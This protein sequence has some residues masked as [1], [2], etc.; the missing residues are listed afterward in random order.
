MGA[1]WPYVFLVVHFTSLLLMSKGQTCFFTEIAGQKGSEML[2]SDS[3]NTTDMSACKTL[4]NTTELCIAGEFLSTTNTCHIYLVETTLTGETESVFFQWNCT[5]ETATTATTTASTTT[6]QTTTTT[7]QPTTTTPTTTMQPTTTTTA[8]TTMQPTSTT[9][10]TTTMQ[11]TT[12][13][14]TTTT[15][16]LRTT[17]TATTTTTTT[18]AS[19][20]TITRTPDS[21]RPSQTCFFTEIAGQKGSEMLHSDSANT[22][23]VSACKTLCNTTE[24]CI[25]G[26]FLSTTNTCHIY[27]VETNLTDQTETMFF[28]W[29][30]TYETATTATTTASTTTM[31]TTTTTTQ[32]TTTTPT[33]TMQTTTTTTQPTTTTTSTT[34]MQTTT[35]S[36]TT[37]TMQPT[38]ITTTTTT[39]QPTTTTTPTT[40]MQPTTTTT[41]TTTMQPT[42][43]TTS[44]TTMQ[45][46]TT[47]PTTTTTTSRTTPTATTT[48]TTTPASMTTI[49]R[50]PDS[51]RPILSYSGPSS[52]RQYDTEGAIAAALAGFAVLMCIPCLMCIIL[53]RK[54]DEEDGRW[55][56]YKGPGLRESLKKEI[57]IKRLSIQTMSTEIR[58]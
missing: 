47:T 1:R 34:T 16:T 30:C 37:T 5:Y 27:L 33:T 23:D 48:T 40:T 17:P 21:K 41:A 58:G 18:P 46:T 29:N 14:P 32:P 51:K 43:T 15:T 3:E 7:T 38:T 20:T 45:P 10:S 31:Q 44:T 39:M 9:T 24:L 11:P 52:G 19:M 26:E 25:A 28:Q 57:F 35:T 50:T 55:V 22:T 2:H 4:C 53:C 49:T 42:S 8:T 36:T 13:T 56:I 54:N 12:T 6:M